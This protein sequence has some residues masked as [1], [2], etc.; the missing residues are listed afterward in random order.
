MAPELARGTNLTLNTDIYSFGVVILEI[1]C[2]RKSSSRRGDYLIDTV[3]VKAEED[4]LSDLV[5]TESADMQNKREEAVKTIR[6]T[7]SCLQTNWYRRPS[8]SIL[9]KAMEGLATLEPLTGF[10]F[11]NFVNVKIPPI[12]FYF[13]TA[14]ILSRPR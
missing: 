1:I 14:S 2:G 5:D 7:I 9:V 11:L 10:S 8:A 4:R 6:I 12:Y 3:K 13:V